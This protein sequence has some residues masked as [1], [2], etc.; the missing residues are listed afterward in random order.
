MTI[1]AG[2]TGQPIAHSL[3]PVIH[4]AWIAAAGLDARYDALAPDGAIGFQALVAQGRRGA[5]RGL[6][7][8]APFKEQALSLADQAGSTARA[9]GSANLLVFEEGSVLA[10]STDG[11]GLLSALAEQAP[12]LDLRSRPVV[13]LGAGGAARA[14]AHALKAA[15]ADV[16]VLNRT[17]ARAHGLAEDLGVRAADADALPEAALVVNALSVRPEIDLSL[18]RSDAV[19]MDMTYRPLMTDFLLAGRARGLV[20]VDG[21]AML[22]G[23]ARPSFRAFFGIEPPAIDIRAVALAAMEAVA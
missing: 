10:Y 18:L 9:C 7:V 17:L 16:G 5:L 15:G 23:Q 3:S 19:L 12:G 14:A 20:I 1:R 2:V 22:I 21:L 8:T 11:E 4:G 13:V 6:N